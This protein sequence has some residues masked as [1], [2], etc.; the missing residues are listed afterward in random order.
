MTGGQ[1]GTV[2]GV[3]YWGERDLEEPAVALSAAAAEGGGALVPLWKPAQELQ[4][5]EEGPLTIEVDLPLHARYL[6]P[7]PSRSPSGWANSLDPPEDTAR[8]RTD[9]LE[10]VVA[11]PDVVWHCLAD[12]QGALSC[13]LSFDRRC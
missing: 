1:G 8:R 13:L 12:T 5:E 7:I 3:E 11:P 2:G 9:L 10:V 4:R 6:R